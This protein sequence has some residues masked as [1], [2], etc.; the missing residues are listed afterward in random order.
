MAG[1][2]CITFDDGYDDVYDNA[3]PVLHA[4]NI[5][6]TSFVVTDWIGG[7]GPSGNCMSAA[8]L[9]TLQTA[10]WE[11]G[12]H[13]TD[14]TELDTITGEDLVDRLADS[15]SALEAL[16]LNCDTIAYPYG[17]YNSEVVTVA[18]NYYE[19]QRAGNDLNLYLRDYPSW[20]QVIG[21]VG[22][23]S[24]QMA[25][26]AID[27]AIEKNG[28]VV[29]LYHHCEESGMLTGLPENNHTI[30]DLAAYIVAKRA[31]DG[32]QAIAFRDIP[33]AA[34]TT[35]T[36]IWDGGGA[37]NLASTAANWKKIAANGT[38]TNDVAPTSGSDTIWNDTS[39][40]D[41]TWDFTTA[42]CSP[43]SLNILSGYSGT[44]TQGAVNIDIGAEGFTHI[45]GN[46]VPNT[47]YAVDCGGPYIY[48]APG[49]LTSNY[50]NMVYSGDGDVWCTG[51][52][53]KSLDL[54]GNVTLL[55]SIT[56]VFSSFGMSEGV[57][58]EIPAS[59]VVTLYYD[60]VEDSEIEGTISGLGTLKFKSIDSHALADLSSVTID[61]P[62]EIYAGS[63]ASENCVITASSAISFG[64][65]LKIYSDHA[66]R[67]CTLDMAGFDV[68]CAG[69][70][71]T[72]RGIFL[73]SGSEANL[74]ADEITVGASAQFDRTNI[75]F[76]GEN[77]VG[78][79]I[80]WVA[81]EAGLASTAAN[82]DLERA[83]FVDDDVVFNGTST[84]NC[85]WDIDAATA[86]MHTIT[87]ASGYTGTV[88]QAAT[89]DMGIGAGGVFTLAAGTFV[90]D[91][92]KSI[93]L[94]SGANFTKTGGTLTNYKTCLVL[95]SGSHAIASNSDMY[96]FGI[97]NSGTTSIGPNIT[98][99]DTGAKF[100]NRAG[101]NLTIATGKVLQIYGN[102]VAAKSLY[103]GTFT[104]PGSMTIR[105]GSSI[106]LNV[107]AATILCPVL[108]T[109]NADASSRT[110]TLTANANF[111]PALTISSLHAS[112]TMTVDMAAKTLSATAITVSTRAVL[113]NSGASAACSCT[114]AF[115]VSGASSVVSGAI[116]LTYG[117]YVQSD[118]SFTQ[119]ANIVG[120]NATLSGGALVGNINNTW[121]CTG[122][123]TDTA[124]T[125]TS[126]VFNLI[127][128]TDGTTVRK[129][130]VGTYFHSITANGNVTFTNGAASIFPTNGLIVAA[131]KSVT[132][133][134]GDVIYLSVISTTT[135]SNKGVI[136]GPGSIRFRMTAEDK[137]VEMGLIAAPTLVVSSSGATGNRV[138]SLSGASTLLSTL[139]MSSDHASNTLTLDTAGKNL[140]V[141]GAVTVGTRGVLLG[142]EG[143]HH[144]G[145]NFNTSAGAVN[146]ET[147][148]I[149]FTKA[150][151]L[152][153]A[154]EQPLYDMLIA[155]DVTLTLG[156]DVTVSHTYGNGGTLIPGAFAL[157][158]SGS[159]YDKVFL[160]TELRAN[161]SPLLYPTGKRFMRR[162]E[163]VQ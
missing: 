124:S 84:Q 61:A 155:P 33:Q 125:F 54:Q 60:A 163:R 149:V 132:V 5:P 29:L 59:K 56:Q 158:A 2:V 130:V 20:R 89:A 32:L 157:T 73:N 4:A 93:L 98:V 135:Y 161:I 43:R 134:S 11:I 131:N 110:M 139:S 88:T 47:S 41:C 99:Y 12:S 71:L 122:N 62:V 44:V 69:I 120:G 38:E 91:T 72:A 34:P 160:P 75:I 22:P 97:D 146:F 14:H 118:G 3:Y 137:T 143:V 147:S 123:W 58:L 45:D 77:V 127:M 106:D 64:S 128:S 142:G 111:G 15:Q 145:G 162:L 74:D 90:G 102:Y 42:A 104:G 7:V 81:A 100:Y 144:L 116:V 115:T 28:A 105:T 85:S 76:E 114:G 133:S 48:I 136:L 141:S 83:P 78:Q 35:D 113:T 13:T 107:S 156:S 138:L 86:T 129:D 109:L 57:E 63:S 150:A 126:A 25:T 80:T 92:G 49:N 19:R 26:D 154:A 27:L 119:G 39:V 21:A 117:T 40:K 52:A 31:S 46:F 55:A 112:N 66:S 108:L 16:G 94:A 9:L 159:S 140:A 6:A 152:K 79:T 95:A 53:F 151:T 37:D 82:W 8:Q 96:L 121:T 1:Y 70:E 148:Q 67:T 87:I 153:T 17:E 23:T 68:S 36:F 24:L 103:A 101:A 65:T 51:A 30:Q 10:G 18:A 50:L